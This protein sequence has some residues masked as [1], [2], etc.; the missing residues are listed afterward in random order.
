MTDSLTQVQLSF[1]ENYLGL[2][3]EAAPDTPGPTLSGLW[4]TAKDTVDDQL[5]GFSDRLRKSGT[6]QVQ[7]VAQEVETLLAPVRVKLVAALMNYDSAPSDPK[8]HQAALKA[9]S[10]TR[11]W[12]DAVARVQVI[13]RNPWNVP[14]SIATTLGTALDELEARL[15]SAGGA[16]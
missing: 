4:Q 11:A 9:L 14:V 13:D 10:E 8:N 5:R 6:P 12:L 16:R 1:L 15:T 7:A 2:R 3:L